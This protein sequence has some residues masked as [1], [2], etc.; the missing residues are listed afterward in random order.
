[1]ALGDNGRPTVTNL[2]ERYQVESDIIG[3]EP[4]VGLPPYAW[5][6]GAEIVYTDEY[7]NTI[8]AKCASDLVRELASL[9]AGD[10]DRDMVT[11]VVDWYVYDEGC[12]LFCDDCNA[13]I[14]SLYGDPDED[15]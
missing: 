11:K 5:P 2:V 3:R 10:E 7:H 12:T 1:M 8:C 15:D 14:K 6:G 13:E 9:P 4:A